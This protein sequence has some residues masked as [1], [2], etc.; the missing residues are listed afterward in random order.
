[1]SNLQKETD[2][3]Q[4]IQKLKFFFQLSLFLILV[5]LFTSLTLLLFQIHQWQDF[6]LQMKSEIQNLKSSFLFTEN[7]SNPSPEETPLPMKSKVIQYSYSLGSF[8]QK[9]GQIAF[10]TFKTTVFTIF[11]FFESWK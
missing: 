9:V 7:I 5:L 8:V 11:T 3:L 4:E 1:M 6:L 10:L 2:L